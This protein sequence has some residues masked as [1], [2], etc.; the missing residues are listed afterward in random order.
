MAKS[1]KRTKKD[2]K[3]FGKTER[4]WKEWG[5]EFG[6]QMKKL[7]KRFENKMERHKEW[8]DT[9]GI[10]GPLFKSIFVILFLAI[11]IWILNSVNF[12]LKSVFVFMVSNFFYM[13]IQWFFLSSLFFGYADYYLRR[14]PKTSWTFAPLIGSLRATF[15]IWILV[16]LFS[17]I[18]FYNGS[19][20]L[21]NF[22]NFINENLQIVFVLLLLM[23]YISEFAKRRND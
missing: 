6:E 9:F 15:V 4:E 10:I 21:T 23:S 1:R 12:Y 3:Y 19:N 7:G 22:V 5:E 2:E 8:H 17:L 14:N 11:G 16:S 18:G 20:V 13:N